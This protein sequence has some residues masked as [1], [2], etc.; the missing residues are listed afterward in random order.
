MDN[1][2][3]KNV[4]YMLSQ[5]STIIAL[6]I[7]QYSPI[8]AVMTKIPMGGEFN[9]TQVIEILAR[10][11]FSN[12]LELQLST[13]NLIKEVYDAAKNNRDCQLLLEILLV[14]SKLDVNEYCKYYKDG[15]NSLPIGIFF[16]EDFLINLLLALKQRMLKNDIVLA[17]QSISNQIKYILTR[18]PIMS[19]FE[20]GLRK[21]GLDNYKERI[22]NYI[23]GMQIYFSKSLGG[24]IQGVALRSG[25]L[26]SL[27]NIEVFG[28]NI[29]ATVAECLVNVDMIK[30]KA[31][32]ITKCCHETAHFL[33][34]SFSNDFNFSSP[35]VCNDKDPNDD[36]KNFEFGR[37]IELCMFGMQPNW[38]K[39]SEEAAMDFINNALVS[40]NLP[41]I[42][43]KEE[44]S[45][46]LIER[47]QPS[48]SFAADIE[49]IDLDGCVG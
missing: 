15:G 8:P 47:T 32:L 22:T 18:T 24:Q 41:L 42:R 38:M 36:S 12:G 27:L 2:I 44:D 17:N 16:E 10:N 11:I 25:V 46:Y 20:E 3:W 28:H 23:N 6:D 43:R 39:S 5:N 45:R 26:V 31:W 19:A 1:K 37:Y 4:E 21:L 48:L 14:A 9:P 40:K 49:C 34:R 13:W 35:N 7:A 29:E 33:A 30:L